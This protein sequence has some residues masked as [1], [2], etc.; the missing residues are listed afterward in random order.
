MTRAPR[1]FHGPFLTLLALA[2]CGS[3]DSA[4]TQDEP[5]FTITP[6]V[7]SDAPP[8]VVLVSIDT[9]RAD[10][11]SSYGYERETTPTIDALA[12]KGVRFEAAYAPMGMTSPS[13]GSL[14][15]SQ[16]PIRLQMTEKETLLPTEVTTLAE[17]LRHAGYVTAGFVSAFE[18]A[19]PFRFNR[20]FAHYDAEYD[21]PE[22]SD[23]KEGIQRR[24]ENTVNATIDW[25]AATTVDY[26]LFLFVH[27]FDPEE[28][29]RPP[30]DFKTLFTPDGDGTRK[31]QIALYDGEIA[32]ADAELGRLLAE[33]DLMRVGRPRVTL[34]T[35]DHGQGLWDH[36]WRSHAAFTYEEELRVPLVIA[37]DGIAEGVVLERPV[38]L[39]DVVPTLVGM[40]GV[41][42]RLTDTAMVGLDLSE[43]VRT[44]VDPDLPTRPLFFQRP[45]R[46]Q[47]RHAGRPSVGHGFGLRFGKWKYF[48][49]LAE[50]TREL[51]DLDSDPREKKN[52]AESNAAMADQCSAM[53]AAWVRRLGGTPR[54]ETVELDPEIADQ[55]RHFGYVD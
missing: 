14:L 16:P 33:L 7:P 40:L 52:L 44:G 25:L 24:A 21:V 55:L 30:G 5:A 54:N 41:E 37:G 29:Y 50:G 20:G 6:D 19:P 38:Q 42:T 18:L 51:Y 39:L 36:E 2:S 43:R 3:E 23:V 31:R 11:V 4:P 48:E 10:H 32:Y 22:S 1:G 17:R 26:P 27:L 35:S 15:T 34:V 47:T 12:A 46:V 8:D 13:H 49:A 9:L 53:I 45:N 28:T